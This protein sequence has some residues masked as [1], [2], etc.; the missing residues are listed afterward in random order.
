MSKREI[1]SFYER[2][3]G[4]R[5]PNRIEAAPMLNN[6]VFTKVPVEYHAD[7]ASAGEIKSAMLSIGR[8][9][10]PG[11][12]GYN[13]AFFSQKLGGSWSR[14]GIGCPVFFSLQVLCLRGGMLQC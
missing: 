5:V 4:T 7:L 6:I 9:K 1:V 11:L 12:D 8:D 14:C 10:A 3:L 13:A 2:L